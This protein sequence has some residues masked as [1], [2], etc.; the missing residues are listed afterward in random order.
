VID[1]NSQCSKKN[2]G[3]AQLPYVALSLWREYDV[4][5]IQALQENPGSRCCMA[6]E[7]SAFASS[8]AAALRAS[9]TAL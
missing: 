6:R 4:Q 7:I 2:L 3:I 1:Q 9:A 5:M 8:L